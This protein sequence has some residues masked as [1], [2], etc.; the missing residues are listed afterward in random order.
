MLYYHGGGFVI[1]DSATYDATP[2]ALAK[3]ANAIMV[4]VDYHLAPEYKFPAAPHDAKN[5]YALPM[6]APSLNGLPPAVIIAEIDPLHD[7]GLAYA[8]HLQHE[9]VA[10]AYQDYRGV[11]HEFFG[12]VPLTRILP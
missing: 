9:G 3:G 5:P 10:V 6:K 11:T 8:T 12:M 4:A 7:E 1:A 2:R